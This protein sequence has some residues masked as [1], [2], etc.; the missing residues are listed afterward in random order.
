MSGLYRILTLQDDMTWR[1]TGE[2]PFDS[3][4][5]AE[6][7]QRTEVGVLSVIAGGHPLNVSL[8]KIEVNNRF[9]RETLC[10]CANLVVDGNVVADI[11]NT[12]G[13]ESHIYLWRDA[14]WRKVVNA[15]AAAQETE[16]PF[17]KLDQIVNKLLEAK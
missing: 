4:G 16:H 8:S 13:G 15:W 11:E 1:D 3:Y 7:F 5:E 12:G 9:S 17:D 14:F 10:F 2:G 6:E